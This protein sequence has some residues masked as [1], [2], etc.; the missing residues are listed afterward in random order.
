MASCQTSQWVSSAPYVKLTVTEKSSTGDTA[1]LQWTLQYIADYA[2]NT[3]VNK[4]YSV[5]LAGSVVKSGTF[6]I[7]GKTGTHT[8]ASGTKTINKTHSVYSA[9][10]SCSFDF[11]LTWSGEYKGT[12]KA[13]NWISISAKTKYTVSYSANGGSDGPGVQ[14]KWHGEALTLSS[15]KSSR[16]GYT[17]QGWATSATGSVAY[18]SGATYTENAN[19]TLYAVWK[20]NTYSVTYNA[21]GGTGA[22]TSQAKTHGQALTLSSVK[23]T[24]EGYNFMGWATAS[25]RTIVD[26]KPGASYTDNKAVT[27]YAIW[28]VS[29]VKPRVNNIEVS[30][31]DATGAPNDASAIVLVRFDYECDFD[32]PDVNVLCKKSNVSGW[33][34]V[35][36]CDNSG[37]SFEQT[38]SPEF[39]WNNLSNEF[40]YTF[41]IYVNDGGSEDGTTIIRSLPAATLGI[42]F[43]PPTET[44]KLGASIGKP[45][46]LPGV[47]DVGLETLVRG[48]FR[49][50]VLEPNTD[51]NDVKTPNTYIGANIASNTYGN[52]PLVSGTF[53]L[54]VEG[55]GEEGQIKQILTRCSKTEPERYMRFFYQSAW[56]TWKPDFS[57]VIYE[58]AT[59][60]D[61]NS[62]VDTGV[63][64][65]NSSHT[66]ANLPSGNVNGWLLVLRADS[67]AIKQIWLR[68]GSPGIND[69][70][71]YCR[72]YSGSKWS[73]WRRLMG[74][75]AV[76]YNRT[77]GTSDAIEIDSDE[78]LS[79]FEYIEVFYADNNG[80]L[81][82]S[83]RIYAPDGK[84]FTLSIIEPSAA[85]KTLIRRTDY[86]CNEYDITPNTTTA[87]Y[88]TLN[89]ATV[90]HTSS[91]TNYIKIIRVLGYFK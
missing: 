76:L 6:N 80:K 88:L 19:I 2:A 74:E 63:W 30:R 79:H 50:L 16:T 65:F 33:D 7:D 71:T 36:H 59:G 26:Y 60:V 37:F 48:G 64:Y 56:S 8:I 61:L 73:E 78:D 10:F 62:Y 52:C 20:A 12:A 1:T 25:G 18:A 84:T 32:N 22:P 81:G 46:E 90:A 44:E 55:A 5:T 31:I 35:I 57:A 51:L 9:V 85:T 23:P 83:V 39:V 86:T 21:N 87:G 58:K 17:F 54:T 40:S 66:P 49:H 3:S 70:N 24:R 82:G 75:P 69:F 68:F 29:Y 91:G 67:G 4:S 15:V 77:A 34:D 38:G 89:G 41:R 53:T 14:T 45:A 43:I 28:V 11:N 72:T 13:T 47:F 27:L 42:D